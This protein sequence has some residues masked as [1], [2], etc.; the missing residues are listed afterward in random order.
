MQEPVE[1]KIWNR[2]LLSKINEKNSVHLGKQGK[3]TFK[4]LFGDVGALLL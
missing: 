4:I 2:F 3:S 1:P